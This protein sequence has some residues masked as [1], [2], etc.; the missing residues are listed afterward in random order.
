MKKRSVSVIALTA[1]FACVLSGCSPQ[2]SSSENTKSDA[3]EVTLV[4]H[5]QFPNE[6]FAAAASKATGLNVK[7]VNIGGGDDLSSKLVLT[8]DAPVAD[9]FFGVNNF[10]ASRLIDEGV[11][12][13]YES[14][15]PDKQF[16]YDNKGSLT[17][18]TDSAVC[19]NS[20]PKWFAE[21]NLPEPKSYAD[22]AKPEYK[23]LTA[24]IDPNASSTGI[25]FMVGTIAKFGENGYLDYWKNLKNNDALI[26]QGW[27]E[28]Y[29]GHF[30][31][32]GEGGT[33][34]LV[35][36][37]ASSPAYTVTEDGTATTSNA[38]LDTCTSMV[39]YAGILK[40]TKNESGAKKV[41]EYLVS[42]EFQDTVAETMYVSPVNPASSVPAEWQKF[43]PA[44][45][46]RNDLT[47]AE[48]G[49]NR[50]KWLQ[51]WDSTING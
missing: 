21:H 51:D 48:I 44:P 37:Y 5:D 14:K 30:T 8:K 35:V 39:E 31:Q 25:A 29:Q 10:F 2:N 28:A 11:V 46:T 50:E 16:A 24:A 34:P 41:I 7:V 33:Y 12:V 19:L 45:T 23:G 6:E 47:A 32:G 13:P 17:A 40:G 43:A 20:D 26:T 1:A 18:V 15:T 38:L 3:N 36:S 49:K 4:V 22:I 42:K 27:S 9:A